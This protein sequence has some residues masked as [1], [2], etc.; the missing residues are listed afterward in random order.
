MK[1]LIE[2]IDQIQVK[3]QQNNFNKDEQEVIITS[4]EMLKDEIYKI[5]L[6]N[7]IELSSDK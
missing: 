2:T 4:L 6:S 1:P 3:L 7:Y 5:E